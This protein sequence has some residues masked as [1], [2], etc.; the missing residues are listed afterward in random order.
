M[1]QSNYI[2]YIQDGT[3][4]ERSYAILIL[5]EGDPKKSYL[6]SCN[7]ELNSLKF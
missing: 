2:F 6:L 4:I 7:Y 3:V 1:L 5:I